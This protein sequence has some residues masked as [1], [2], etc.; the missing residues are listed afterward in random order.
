MADEQD[1]VGENDIPKHETYDAW[2]KLRGKIANILRR[3]SRGDDEE[4]Q[5]VMH[6]YRTEEMPT[7][8]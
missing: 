3:D 8:I 7:L 1:I 2:W 4:E 6:D 5:G